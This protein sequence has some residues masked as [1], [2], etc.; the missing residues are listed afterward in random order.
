M[1]SYFH[2]VVGNFDRTIAYDSTLSNPA[3]P[4]ITNPDS[5]ELAL[6]KPIAPPTRSYYFPCRDRSNRTIYRDAGGSREG[7]GTL[8]SL[9]FYTYPDNY[10]YRFRYCI[11]LAIAYSFQRW[12]VCDGFPGGQTWFWDAAELSWPKGLGRKVPELRVSILKWVAFN[13]EIF[14]YFFF[15]TEENWN[16]F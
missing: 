14:R 8:Y 9:W 13:V 16:Y 6:G 2:N 11:T 7:V 15:F 4:I 10:Y 12:K 1:N 3:N 5:I